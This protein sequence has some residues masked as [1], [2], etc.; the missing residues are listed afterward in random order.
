MRITLSLLKE[1]LDIKQDPKDI[2]HLFTS[3]GIEV[4]NIENETPAFTNVFS[5]KV[6][7]V[8]KHPKADN[9]VIAKVTDG[10][11]IFQVVCG[12]KNCRKDLITAFAKIGASLTD[13]K[14]NIFKVNKAKLRDV[15]SFGMLCSS[16]E[17]FQLSEDKDQILELDSNFEIGKDLSFLSNPIFEISLTPN[18]GHLM[19]ALGLARELSC[20]T[21][22]KIK[23]PAL[24]MPPLNLKEESTENIEKDLKVTIE[25]QRCKRYTARIIDNVTIAPS[26]FW[27]KNE[28]EACGFRSI[29]NVVDATN[30]IMLKFN[31]P[32]HA[33]DYDKIENHELNVSTNDDEIDFTC[34]DQIDRKIPKNSLVIKDG[35]KPV[36][37]AGIIGGLNSSVTDNTKKIVLEAAHFEASSIRKTSKLL[38]LKT[39]SSIRF[40]KSIDPNMIPLAIDYLAAL[41]AEITNGNIKILK[42]KI[43]IKKDKFLENIKISIRVKKAQEI[44]GTKISEN[45]ILDIFERLDF[46]IVEKN[47]DA[48]LVQVPTYRN[49]ISHEIDLIEEIARIYGYNNIAKVNPYYRSSTATHSEKYLFERD[50][51][52]YLRSCSLQEIKTCDLISPK[53]SEIT[54]LNI[55]KDSLVKVKHFKSIDQ[56]ILR[57]TLLPSL[58]EVVK[59][60]H[61]RKNFDI[62]GY[63]IGKVHFKNKDEYIERDTLSLIMSGKRNPHLWDKTNFDVNFYDLKGILEN[64]LSAV[65]D[66]KYK[67]NISN[68]KGFHPLKQANI[69]LDDKEFAI[70][71]EVHPNILKSSFDIKKRVFFAEL[72]LNFIFQN[73]IDQIDFHKISELPSSFRD[74]TLS[75]DEKLNIQNIFDFFEKIK[76]NILE[77]I[78]LVDLFKN[79]EDKKNATFR[80]IYRN[81]EKTISNE[82]IE[83]QH[84]KITKEITKH[85]EK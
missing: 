73:R 6:L 12:A 30:Y 7:E 20:L 44:L 77:K 5:V 53:L 29:N 2:A 17:L 78:Y 42:G 26:P 85:L 83:E 46:K 28:L 31:H 81:T 39:Q 3:A 16:F 54:L 15:E 58:L 34:L 40:E 41:I 69:T 60:N 11:D 27:L 8:E 14:G 47:E 79:V 10:K 84:L 57:P 61:D 55:D 52:S 65:L 18:L 22:Q 56:S 35:K 32:M 82:E 23:M 49:D 13:E 67:F 19:S 36:A 24:I 4:D 45:E 51:K 70:I 1:F 9:L 43:D 74:L 48:I 71:G 37:I 75:I 38:N 80:F 25:D 59:F 33:F 72:D 68:R 76:S 63:E 62:L 50:I 66:K 64:V 21:K